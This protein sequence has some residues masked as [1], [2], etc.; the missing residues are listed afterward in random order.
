M[1]SN[2][3]SIRRGPPSASGDGDYVGVGWEKKCGRR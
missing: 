1:K 2:L 3:P